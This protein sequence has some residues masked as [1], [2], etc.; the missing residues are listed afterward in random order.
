MR[1]ARV[2]AQCRK[3]LNDGH[4]CGGNILATC[5][6]RKRIPTPPLPPFLSG[7]GEPGKTGRL[8]EQWRSSP[9]RDL[10]PPAT[11]SSTVQSDAPSVSLHSTRYKTP[12]TVSNQK[13]NPSR[14]ES[15]DLTGAPP[16]LPIDLRLTPASIL[17][18]RKTRGYSS[19]PAGSNSAPESLLPQAI[20][21]PPPQGEIVIHPGSDGNGQGEVLR[22]GLAPIIPTPGNHHPV[23]P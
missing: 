22:L 4:E 5:A 11:S 13:W 21:E 6:P 10:P 1:E 12:G 16:E 23:R 18:Q 14:A 17:Y 9:S 19:I 3:G 15:P 8:R 2:R 20:S 7:P